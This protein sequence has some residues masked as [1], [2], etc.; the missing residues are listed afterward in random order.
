MLVFLIAYQDQADAARRRLPPSGSAVEIRSTEEF[1][2]FR[3][4]MG[5]QHDLVLHAVGRGVPW[6]ARH[7]AD[8]TCDGE[9]L[10]EWYSAGS[11]PQGWAGLPWV[12]VVN[13]P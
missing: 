6:W 5:A 13:G 7:V 8:G 11:M 9:D 2:K 4:A 10:E 12:T 1:A 3:K